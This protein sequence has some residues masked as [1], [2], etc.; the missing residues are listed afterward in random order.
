[1]NNI[2]KT[3]A[4]DEQQSDKIINEIIKIIAKNNLTVAQANK[5]LYETKEQIAKQ[6]ITVS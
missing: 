1:M 3:A 4:H 2:E 5:I 6:V